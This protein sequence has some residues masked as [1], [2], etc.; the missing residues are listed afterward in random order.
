[1]SIRQQYEMCIC[2]E[3]KVTW[4][5]H[6][7]STFRNKKQRRDKSENRLGAVILFSFYKALYLKHASITM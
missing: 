4:F 3:N 1:M 6:K 5:I 7:T 2:E